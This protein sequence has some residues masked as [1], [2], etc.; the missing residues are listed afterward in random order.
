MK[1][2]SIVTEA[3]LYNRFE[4]PYTR[5]ECDVKHVL[6]ANVYRFFWPAFVWRPYRQRA[7]SGLWQTLQR[8]LTRI[9]SRGL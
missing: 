2:L 1:F 6:A 9:R 7:L 3:R 8:I 5:E 4:A